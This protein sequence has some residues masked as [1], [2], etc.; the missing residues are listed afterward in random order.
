MSGDIGDS[1]RSK[2]LAENVSILRMNKAS[3]SRLP[4]GFIPVDMDVTSFDKYKT[5]KHGPPRL[6]KAMT[7]YLGTEGY[8]IH[9]RRTA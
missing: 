9:Q 7:A 6:T 4:N 8:L 3:P 5:K 2:I 1:L